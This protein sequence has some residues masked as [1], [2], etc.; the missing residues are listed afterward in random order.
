MHGVADNM[1]KTLLLM[2]LRGLA[3][4]VMSFS[5]AHST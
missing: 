3:T 1:Y 2:W 5:Q 4:V